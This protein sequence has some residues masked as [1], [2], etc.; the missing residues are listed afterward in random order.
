MVFMCGP[1]GFVVVC[2][3]DTPLSVKQM[4][5]MAEGRWNVVDGFKLKERC[6]SEPHVP[7]L[8]CDRSATMG[9]AH[10]AGQ[11]PLR[12]LHGIPPSIQSRVVK[13]EVIER[14]TV[15]KLDAGLFKNG[16]PL[17]GR[18]VQQLA[19]TAVTQFRIEGVTPRAVRNAAAVARRMMGTSRFIICRGRRA[20]V[21]PVRVF[22]PPLILRISR[23]S[24][25]ISC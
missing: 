23:C 15:V 18:P 13:V 22:V 10:L 11:D 19:A 1:F 24:C 4:A 2:H 25:E 17:E 5:R 7:P 12:S 9:T 16:D 3:I 20:K 21:G 8:V 14:G 6:E